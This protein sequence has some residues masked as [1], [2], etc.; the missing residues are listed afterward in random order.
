[1][2]STILFLVLVAI[3]PVAL[4]SS[5]P[6]AFGAGNLDSASPYGLTPNEKEIYDN[7][8]KLAGLNQKTMTVDN[9]IDSLRERVDGFQTVL[10][11]MNDQVHQNALDI[12]SILNTKNDTNSSDRNA[13]IDA[14]IKA[15]SD[16]FEKLKQLMTEMSSMIDGINSKYVSKDDFN[17]LVK[18]IN[19]LKKDI[20]SK[21][22]S[23]AKKNVKNL[24]SASLDSMSQAD[25]YSKANSYYEGKDYDNSYDYFTYLI[26]KNYKP[27]Y[28]NYMAGEIS[29]KKK[30]YEDAMSYY[31]QS[32]TLYSTADYMPTLM[33]HTGISMQ[34]T[35][36]I[37][38]AKQFFN[39][40]I[41]QFPKSSEAK[42][43]KKILSSLK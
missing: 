22:S 43:A 27:A 13:Q 9:K 29:Y 21:Q 10:E 11:G 5:E 4:L 33:L 25:V 24:P 35:K 37:D 1:M 36:D 34:K 2:K 14:A 30:N 28:S 26:S 23:T 41:G 20:G 16:N 19:D 12:K 17:A 15:N 42:E 32:A 38:N 31:K 39:A 40:L 8:Q 7:K 18:D 3:L 6:S